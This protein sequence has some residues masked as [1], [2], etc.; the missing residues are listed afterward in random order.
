MRDPL[1]S[2]QA[3]GPI[4]H[5]DVLGSDKHRHL[6][7]FAWVVVDL[8]ERRACQRQ[9]PQHLLV[10]RAVL[11][12]HL[13]KLV[14]HV[15]AHAC[16]G[17]FLK[18]VGLTHNLRLHRPHC[19]EGLHHRLGLEPH[20]CLGQ[21]RVEYATCALPRFCALFVVQTQQLQP[22]N[23]GLNPVLTVH[24]VLD[25][26]VNQIVTQSVKLSFIHELG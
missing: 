1:G 6:T 25:K 21:H 11:G 23:V 19:R 8:L 22:V 14:V 7:A 16:G 2:L 5:N 12:H 10:L 9:R 18:Y 15:L 24:A 4:R 26:I 13:G 17:L 20:N 3:T